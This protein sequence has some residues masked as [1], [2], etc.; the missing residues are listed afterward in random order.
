MVER[1]LCKLEVRGSNPLASS[2][3]S[4][5]RGKRRLSRRSLSE[6]G[7][8]CPC[9]CTRGEL[10]LGKP[11]SNGKIFLHLHIASDIDPKRFYTGLTKHLPHR[12]QNHNA[13]R[14]L[15]TAKWKPLALEKLH[16]YFSSRPCCKTRPISEICFW[17]SILK[18]HL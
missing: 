17:A 6:G 1:Q 2:L 7:P 4:R 5:R 3:R 9:G 16:R 10:R 12:V 13:G 11:T 18:K 14:V 15:H 8:L